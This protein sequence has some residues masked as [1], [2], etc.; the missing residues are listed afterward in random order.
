MPT[1]MGYDAL[2]AKAL[3]DLHQTW[4]ASEAVWRD[5]ARTDFTHAHLEPIA[6]RIRLAVRTLKQLESLLESMERDCA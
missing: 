1:V 2:L 6:D 5:Q 3:R 4:A